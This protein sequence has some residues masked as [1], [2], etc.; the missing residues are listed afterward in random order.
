[1]GEI[2]SYIEVLSEDWKDKGIKRS[3]LSIRGF[4]RYFRQEHGAQVRERWVEYGLA[5]SNVAEQV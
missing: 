4:A 1:M 3:E 5:M 2:I